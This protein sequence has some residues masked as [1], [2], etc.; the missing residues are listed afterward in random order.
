MRKRISLSRVMLAPFSGRGYGT[1]CCLAS[2]T[3][4]GLREIRVGV[5][6]RQRNRKTGGR[7]EVTLGRLVVRRARHADERR[8]RRIS[9]EVSSMLRFE[10]EV[11]CALI[12]ELGQNR[13]RTSTGERAL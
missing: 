6:F 1:P 10:P 2:V 4:S 5:Y 8:C 11:P 7:S 12:H 9:I 13:V 3:P